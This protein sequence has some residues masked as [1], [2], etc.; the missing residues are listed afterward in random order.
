M[1]GEEMEITSLESTG[2]SRREWI[3]SVVQAAGAGLF[4]QAISAAQP[5]WHP[6]FLTTTQNEDLV[7]LGEA[8]VPGSKDAFC[9]RVID[10][11]LS[12]ES[13]KNKRDFTQALAAFHSAAHDRYGKRLADLTDGQMQELLGRASSSGSSLSP[14]FELLKEWLAD[15]YWTSKQGLKELGWTGRVAWRS[16]D[17]CPH[18]ARQ[19]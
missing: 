2:L 3:G 14:Q 11:V 18:E 5:S 10:L 13:E 15:T 19:T 4:A 12:I 7:A 6:A 16:F 8:I 17:G 1:I 9:N